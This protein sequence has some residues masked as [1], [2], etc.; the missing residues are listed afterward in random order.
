M[1][2]CHLTSSHP[3]Y[4]TR[5]F[6]KECISIARAG[7]EITLIVADGKGDELIEGVKIVDVGKEISRKAQILKAPRKVFKK[8]L[9]IDAE[10]YHFHDPELISIGNKLRKQKKIVIYDAHEDIPRALLTRNWLPKFFMRIVSILFEQFENYYARKFNAILT[11]TPYI[12]ERFKKINSLTYTIN[13]FPI[14]NELNPNRSNV[15]RQNEICYIGGIDRIRGIIQIMDALTLTNNIKLNLA[16]NFENQALEDEVKSHPSW[17]KVNY[18]G[19]VDRTEAAEILSKSKAGLV[20]FLPAPNH[21]HARP[22]KMFEYMSAGLPVIASF[23][24]DWKAIV[25]DSKTG[26]T[27]D[28]EKPDEIAAAIKKLIE[29]DEIVTEMAINGKSA[30]K[31][32]FNWESEAL[33]LTKIYSEL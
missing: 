22:N 32:I 4:D 24:D 29:N 6:R 2:I 12:S 13:N 25:D 20:T 17:G 23:F 31:N 1:K 33:K 10:I 9:K 3:R 28:P 5:V 18:Y 19:F 7:Y 30:I 21:I 15:K 11:A 8:A 14:L 16:G 26:L 27:V